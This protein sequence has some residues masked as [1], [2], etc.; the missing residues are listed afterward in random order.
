MPLEEVDSFI[1]KE[2]HLPNVPSAADVLKDGIDIAL[3]NAK[4]LEKIEELTLYVI[5]Q[6]KQLDEQSKKIDNL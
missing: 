1:R 2:K 3:M 6:Q 5:M 4:L